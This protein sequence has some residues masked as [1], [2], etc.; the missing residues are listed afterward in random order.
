MVLDVVLHGRGVYQPWVGDHARKID[1]T[2]AASLAE[3]GVADV[4]GIA[5]VGVGEVV[6]QLL[7]VG[8]RERVSVGTH[9]AGGAVHHAGGMVVGEVVG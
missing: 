8:V 1:F 7:G 9:A 4:D 2:L 3:S 5:E 6:E